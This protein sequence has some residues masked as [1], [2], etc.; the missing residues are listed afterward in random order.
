M[1]SKPS[2]VTDTGF[3]AAKL[4]ELA[5]VLPAE[6]VLALARS[7]QVAVEAIL[8]RLNEAA[9]GGDFDTIRLEAHNLRGT[10]G[11]FGARHLQGLAE[12]LELASEAGAGAEVIVLMTELRGAADSA[13]RA[14]QAF[15][16][17]LESADNDAG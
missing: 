6:Q 9:A 11:S 17:P 15:V 1:S 10:S 8:S 14:I 2:I 12:D 5:A 16:A 7:Y 13:W 3:E 4:Q